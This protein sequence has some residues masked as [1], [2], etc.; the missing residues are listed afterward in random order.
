MIMHP[1]KFSFP[2]LPVSSSS[3][4][5]E[6]EAVTHRTSTVDVRGSEAHAADSP[7]QTLRSLIGSRL[8]ITKKPFKTL[9]INH[10]PGCL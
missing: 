7:T 6:H 2:L 5:L 1:V 4:P 8:F 9:E 3:F 10:L